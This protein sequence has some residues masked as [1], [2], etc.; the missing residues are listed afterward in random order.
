MQEA[1][2]PNSA[3]EAAL[4]AGAIACVLGCVVLFVLFAIDC[5]RGTQARW[6]AWSED[7]LRAIDE[8][9]TRAS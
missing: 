1:P 5:H 8:R 6:A 9:E 7:E 4:A 3:A 2:M